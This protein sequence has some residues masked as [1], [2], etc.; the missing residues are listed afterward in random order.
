MGEPMRIRIYLLFALFAASPAFADVTS[1]VKWLTTQ[2]AADGSWGVPALSFSDTQEAIDALHLAQKGNSGNYYRGI[3]WLENHNPVNNDGQSRKLGALTDRGDPT[4]SPLSDLDSSSTT[5][6]VIIGA[7]GWGLGGSLQASPYDTALVLRALAKQSTVPTEAGAIAYLKATRLSNSGWEQIPGTGLDIITTAQVIR[8]LIPYQAQ[9]ST[10][11]AI[12]SSASTAMITAVVNAGSNATVKQKSLALIVAAAEVPTSPQIALWRTAIQS[13]QL[14]DGSWEEDPFSTAI[15]MQALATSGDDSTDDFTL[16]NMPDTNL[17]AAV[18]AALG[19]NAGDAITRGELRSLTSLNAAN[20]G[21]TDLTG[22]QFATNLTSLNLSGNDITTLSPIAA[23]AGVAVVNL[24]GNPLTA[25]GDFDHDGIYDSVE[26]RWGLDPAK[27]D[28][29]GDGVQDGS[30]PFPTL[31]GV[32]SDSDSAPVAVAD[33]VQTPENTT[34]NIFPLTNDSDADGDPLTI[35]QINPPLH[36]TATIVGTHLS[37][38]STHSYFGPDSITYWITDGRGGFANA[39]INIQVVRP[40]VAPVAVPD[41]VNARNRRGGGGIVNTYH[42]TA[43]DTDA[44]G[45]TLTITSIT[46]PTHGIAV[47]QP[48]GVTVLYTPTNGYN[49]VDSFTYTISDGFGGTATG[50]VSIQVRRGSFPA[51]HAA[52]VLN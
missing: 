17:R 52:D 13:A 23:L 25:T 34:L 11:A 15:A 39:I 27:A 32:F 20:M 16:V 24:S 43:N 45:D 47:L 37:Y 7:S 50:T 31:V 18:N 6:T 22:L 30:D 46:Q 2:Q 5:S 33:S 8:A 38:T 51:K 9:D 28:T 36:G 19:H 26:Q 35:I 44:D 21:I 3:A 14:S 40:N 42:P 12:L 48:D 49:G 10:L 41:S 4:A 1:S 29:D